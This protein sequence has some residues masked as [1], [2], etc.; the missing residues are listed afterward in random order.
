[1]ARSSELV[2]ASK[3]RREEARFR[4][5]RSRAHLVFARLEGEV[6]GR[7][8]RAVVRSDTSISADAALLE[9]ARVVTALADTFQDGHIVASLS[10]DPL[11]A[12]LTLTRA[13]DRVT[14]MEVATGSSRSGRG[15]PRP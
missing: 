7:P 12:A 1:M 11:T 2:T 8:V 9:Q 14:A 3:R 4:V 15:S 10:R 13:C 5:L 6:N